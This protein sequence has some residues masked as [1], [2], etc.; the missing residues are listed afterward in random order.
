MCETDEEGQ[1]TIKLTDFGFATFF[2]K[3]EPE[4]LALGSPLYMAPELC[5]EMYYDNKVDVWATGVITFALLTG[6]A[7]FSG[8]SKKEIYDQIIKREPN[9]AKL[10]KVS[11][12]AREFIQACLKKEPT[13]RPTMAELLEMEWFKNF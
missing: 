2:Q 9:Y 8:R 1:I 13:E 10:G 6:Q 12:A 4:T 7:P 3:D 5:M 11:P